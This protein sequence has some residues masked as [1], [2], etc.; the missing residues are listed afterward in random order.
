M[1]RRPGT[2]NGFVVCADGHTHWGRLGAAGLLLDDGAGHTLLQHRAPWTHE[3]G[4]WSVTGGARDDGEDAVTAA[5]RESAEEAGLAASDVRPVGW[6]VVDH[7]GWTYTTVV[8]T[9]V[10]ARPEPRARNDES[11]EIRWW[12]DDKI[13]DLALHAGF[14]ASWG[15]LRV[16]P[17][18][19]TVLVD[20]ANVMGSRPDGWWRDRAGAATR[21]RADLTAGVTRG[22]PAADLPAGLDA[23]PLDALTPR[24]RLVLEGAARGAAAPTATGWAD[25]L[26]TVVDAPGSGDDTVAAEAERLAAT[27]DQLLVVTADRELRERIRAVA[28]DAV[29][30]GPRSLPA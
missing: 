6:S 2:G 21:W 16:R 23:G 4:T 17:R 30:A 25:A 5:L 8:A 10:G 28:P 3:G 15:V 12:P 7:D 9:T 29:L 18:P 13:D 19:L 20:V 26:V 24:L 11:T 22:W 1:R 14:A 27:D